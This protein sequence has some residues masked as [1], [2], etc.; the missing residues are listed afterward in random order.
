MYTP[1]VY[2]HAGGL[3]ICLR[4]NTVFAPTYKTSF[5]PSKKFNKVRILVCAQLHYKLIPS[6]T[7]ELKLFYQIYFHKIV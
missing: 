6:T 1:L 7:V 5:T 2:E 3:I 4:L